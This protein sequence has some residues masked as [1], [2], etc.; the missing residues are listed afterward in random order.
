WTSQYPQYQ[1]TLRYI[2]AQRFHRALDKVQRLVVQRLL[3]MTKANASGM[4]YK[5]RTSIGKAMKTRSKAIHNALKKYNTL[6]LQMDPPAPILEWKDVM[7]YAFVSEFDLLHHMY[8]HKDISQLPW[9]VQVNREIAGKYYK[10]KCAQ[11]EIVRLN[12]ECRRLQTH[13][14][15]EEA[16]HLQVIH[17]L[18]L[19]SP[20]LA[21]EVRKA[22]ENRRRVNRIHKVRLG[23]I[24]SLEG[25][26]GW[27]TEGV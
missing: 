19:D 11:D 1:E 18:T 8:S 25:F 27:M 10:I 21:A 26:S 6:A 7:N 20:L 15:D 5:L 4:S 9:A 16:T 12:I 24:Q 14:R 13:I 22:Y 3:E 17:R 2:Q 23:A